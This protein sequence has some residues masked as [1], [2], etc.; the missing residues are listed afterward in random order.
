MVYTET[1]DAENS[2]EGETSSLS[3]YRSGICYEEAC[4]EPFIVAYA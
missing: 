3:S 4:S 2:G 1:D